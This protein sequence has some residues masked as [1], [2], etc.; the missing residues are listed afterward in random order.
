MDV[1]LDVVMRVSDTE[2]GEAS[3][4]GSDAM[5]RAIEDPADAYLSGVFVT[6]AIPITGSPFVV[7]MGFR[8]P[9][10]REVRVAGE[11]WGDLPPLSE[12]PL[13]MFVSRVERIPE[14]W[15]W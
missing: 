7:G 12:G 14:W 8:G 13:G 4:T 1:D 11:P 10:A 3:A 2:W 15:E 5:V 6:G 9:S